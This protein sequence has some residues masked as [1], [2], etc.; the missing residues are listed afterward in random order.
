MSYK[1][2]TLRGPFYLPNANNA[3]YP[4]DKILVDKNGEK[5]N[6]HGFDFFQK[7]FWKN[8]EFMS[9]L[10]KGTERDIVIRNI[11]DRIAKLQIEMNKVY[12]YNV[13]KQVLE[14]V[15]KEEV[16]RLIHGR[17][18]KVLNDEK[19][20][21]RKRKRENKET[22]AS[23]ASNECSSEKRQVKKR[24]ENNTKMKHDVKEED[25]S[26][27]SNKITFDEQDNLY[28]D[29][30][31]KKGDNAVSIFD[32]M[33]PSKMDKKTR[34]RLHYLILEL[35]NIQCILLF[36]TCMKVLIFMYTMEVI[37]A[38]NNLCIGRLCVL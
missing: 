38:T 15:K 13:K 37:N 9:R 33:L 32:C 7:S 27:S 23:N 36:I 18:R 10:S 2:D 8:R 29:L 25:S 26:K 16:I 14:K 22:N 12:R 20:T 19:N 1:K 30:M 6:N 21:T 4:E 28:R 17:V 35:M 11:N 31:L 3:L 5:L 34:M 24:K